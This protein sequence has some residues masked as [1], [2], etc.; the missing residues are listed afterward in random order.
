MEAFTDDISIPA[1][2]LCGMDRLKRGSF[3]D[4]RPIPRFP[5]ARTRRH[6]KSRRHLV[7]SIGSRTSSIDGTGQRRQIEAGRATGSEA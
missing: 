5:G 1:N 3:R 4:L 2:Q 6:E 7:C